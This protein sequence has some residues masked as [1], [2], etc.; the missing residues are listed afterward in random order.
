MK[1]ILYIHGKGG[2]AQEAEHYQPLF[3]ESTVIGFDYKA[4]TPWEAKEEFSRFYEEQSKDGDAVILIANSIGAFFA[5]HA[6]CDKHIAKAYFISPIVD[7]ETLISDMMKWAN[8]TEDRLRQ[9][10]EIPTSF[11]EALSWEYLCYVREHPIT[12]KIPTDILYGENDHLTSKETISAFAH[13]IGAT[14]TIAQQAEH[15]FH[16]EE[17]MD[18]LDKWIQLAQ[19]P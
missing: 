4:E 13:Q 7:M 1:R 16:T 10:K 12:W 17:Q 5:M 9:E 2:N 8:V 6:L 15:W 11:G 18:T 19:N 3:K 14:L